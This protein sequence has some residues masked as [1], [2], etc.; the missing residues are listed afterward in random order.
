MTTITIERELLEEVVEIFD[1]AISARYPH[2][3]LRDLRAEL[4]AP[5]ERI[6]ELE[7]ENEQLRKDV[8]RYQWLKS[9]KGL[10]LES[11][12]GAPWTRENGSTFIP[13]HRLCAGGTQFA[14]HE[15]LDGAIDAA[16]KGTP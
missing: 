13:S 9:A 15:T 7:V 8:D 16:M 14:P 6:K 5:D 1:S 11:E 3:I 10:T 4:A 12:R 2:E